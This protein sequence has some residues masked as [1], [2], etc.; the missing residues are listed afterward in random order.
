MTL[1]E[2]RPPIEMRHDTHGPFAPCRARTPAIDATSSSTT[3]DRTHKPRNGSLRPR[4]APLAGT[5]PHPAQ[6]SPS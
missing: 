4:V 1:R 6:R 5:K 2:W 3:C